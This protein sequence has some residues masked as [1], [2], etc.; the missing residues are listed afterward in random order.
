M[1]EKISDKVRLEHAIKAIEEIFSF[2]GT[3]T[4][5][6]FTQDSMLK[7]ACMHQLSIIGDAFANLANRIKQENSSIDWKGFI[8]LRVKIVHVYFGIDYEIV[9]NIIKF[10]LPR[11]LKDLKQISAKLL[12]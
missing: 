12:E 2:I 11:L 9:W 6:E 5:N 10:E 4:Y 7:S 1:K 8:G 3:K